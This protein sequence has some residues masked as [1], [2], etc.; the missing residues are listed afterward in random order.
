M[1]LEKQDLTIGPVGENLRRRAAADGPG[2]DISLCGFNS[3]DVSNRA[4]KWAGQSP[5]LKV[6]K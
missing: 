4:K 3:T 5:A 6:L 1:N 2:P